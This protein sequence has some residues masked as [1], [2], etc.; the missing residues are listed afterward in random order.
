MG[1]N[2]LGAATIII[3]A[4]IGIGLLGVRGAIALVVFFPLFPMQL[5]IEDILVNARFALSV[6][7]PD[8]LATPLLRV[9][10]TSETNK[11]EGWALNPTL[12]YKIT[13]Q[14]RP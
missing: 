13:T 6:I 12:L 10:N 4:L 3:A 8:P 5:P 1:R 9:L 11:K 7:M 14:R 2:P